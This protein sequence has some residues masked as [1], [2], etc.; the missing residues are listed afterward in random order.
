MNNIKEKVALKEKEYFVVIFLDSRG[1]VITEETIAVGTVSEVLVH[2]REV[3]HPAIRHRASAIILV[4]NHPSG[5]F[6]PSNE[7]LCLTRDLKKTGEL[8]GIA[9]ED[10]LI[11]SGNGYYS[12]RQ[13]RVI[14]D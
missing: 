13:K 3:F 7:D 14:F 1:H 5:D 4:H 8:I 9:V 6:N 2:P 12:F 11:V 10:H